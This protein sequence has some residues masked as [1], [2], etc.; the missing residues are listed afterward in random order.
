MQ[1][2][3]EEELEE[4]GGLSD[5]EADGELE[6]E[7][8]PAPDDDSQQAAEAMMQ[9]GNLAYYQQDVHDEGQGQIPQ[10]QGKFSSTVIHE[11]DTLVN[12]SYLLVVI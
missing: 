11:F 6:P 5:G 4:V 8:I 2:S 10:D 9:L 7:Q 1:F 12:I 3:S